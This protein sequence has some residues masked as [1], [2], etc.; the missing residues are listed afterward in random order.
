MDKDS[1]EITF[2]VPIEYIIIST[3]YTSRLIRKNTDKNEWC[4][5][6]DADLVYIKDKE[7]TWV[8]EGNSTHELSAFITLKNLDGI[9]VFRLKEPTNKLNKVLNEADACVGVLKDLEFCGFCCVECIYSRTFHGKFAIVS[10]DCE[11][12]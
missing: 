3:G 9:T 8:A 1:G 2:A 4:E 5:E 11:S 10:V 12:G 7:E 6:I